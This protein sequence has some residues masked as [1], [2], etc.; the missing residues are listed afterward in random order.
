VGPTQ[1]RVLAMIAELGLETFP[2]HAEGR[3]IFERKGRTST[4]KGT[5]PV[6][7]TYR[8]GRQR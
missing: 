4:Y 7:Y 1:E 2:T 3:N 6:E 5:I 8:R